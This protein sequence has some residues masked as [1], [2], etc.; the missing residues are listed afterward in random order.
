M[1][2]GKNIENCT[3]NIKNCTKMQKTAKMQKNANFLKIDK[4]RGR[5]F[6]ERQVFIL[7]ILK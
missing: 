5:D 2:R 3:K 6:P 1:M 4:N 7:L